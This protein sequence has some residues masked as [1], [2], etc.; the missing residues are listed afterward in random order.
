MCTIPCKDLAHVHKCVCV[1]HQSK[2][3]ALAAAWGPPG[4]PLTALG[5][6][7]RFVAPPPPLP[8]TTVPI[9]HWGHHNPTHTHT[10]IHTPE[11]MDGSRG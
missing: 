2:V 1:V 8:P 5:A 11:R 7:L 4:A 3:T 10:Y 9:M 6:R